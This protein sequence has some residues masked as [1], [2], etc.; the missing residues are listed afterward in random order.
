MARTQ[1]MY[2]IKKIIFELL[3]SYDNTHKYTFSGYQDKFIISESSNSMSQTEDIW[4]MRTWY[5]LCI[6]QGRDRRVVV[7]GQTVDMFT[8][9]YVPFDIPVSG[10]IENVH[11]IL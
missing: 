5:H 3:I 6:V 1:E 10:S 4:P 9:K 11:F 2:C 7:D 8:F